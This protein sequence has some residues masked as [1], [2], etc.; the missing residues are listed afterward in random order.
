MSKISANLSW[1]LQVCKKQVIDRLIYIINK[2]I[3]ELRK[4]LNNVATLIT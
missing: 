2:I 4:F 3:K 1:N